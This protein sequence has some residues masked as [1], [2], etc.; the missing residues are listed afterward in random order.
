MK[1]CWETTESAPESC[2]RGLLI[3]T[4]VPKKKISILDLSLNK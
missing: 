4:I 3:Y 1:L 2:V